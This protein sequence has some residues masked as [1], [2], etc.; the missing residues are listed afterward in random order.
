MDDLDWRGFLASCA[1]DAAE[2]DWL[3]HVVHQ[4]LLKLQ[5]SASLCRQCRAA[6][7]PSLQ[8]LSVFKQARPSAPTRAAVTSLDWL[9][10]SGAKQRVRVD[11]PKGPA[12]SRA[13]KELAAVMRWHGKFVDIALAA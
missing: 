12:C 5:P 2:L 1:A 9:L 11:I 3:T 7:H 10:R 4:L 8:R 13:E 6:V